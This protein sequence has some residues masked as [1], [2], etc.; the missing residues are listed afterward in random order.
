MFIRKI[1]FVV[2]RPRTDFVAFHLVIKHFIACL[3]YSPS[4]LPA[5]GKII[6]RLSSAIRALTKIASHFFM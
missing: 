6:C 4:L 2:N 3:D 5:N 1:N